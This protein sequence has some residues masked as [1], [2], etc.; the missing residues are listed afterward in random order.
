[1]HGLHAKGTAEH[2]ATHLKEFAERAEW[3]AG[4]IGTENLTDMHSIAYMIVE[5][6]DMTDVRDRLK[7][8]RAEWVD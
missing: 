2:H 1:M 3:S 7:P 4:E 8:Q 6:K 5:E